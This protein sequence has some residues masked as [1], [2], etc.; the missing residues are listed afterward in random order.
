MTTLQGFTDGSYDYRHQYDIVDWRGPLPGLTINSGSILH[1][2]LQHPKGKAMASLIAKTQLA[3]FYNDPQSCFTLFVPVN[4]QGVKCM[5]SYTA[6]QLL[7]LHSLP[8][9]ACYSF[10]KSSHMMFLDTR[11]TGRKIL[12]E[13][14]NTTSPTL[15]RCAQIV[16]Q[17]QVGGSMVYFITSPLRL[18]GNPL[19]NDSA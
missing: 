7:L 1:F 14:I 12:L 15:D 5:D 19:A 13:N 6:Q 18:D 17:V 16:S 2:L 3:G 11:M 8:F 9:S 10:L 4:L